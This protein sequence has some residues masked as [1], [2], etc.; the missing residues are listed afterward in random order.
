MRD[1]VARQA[2]GK[3]G[4]SMATRQRMFLSYTCYTN[5]EMGLSINLA[6]LAFYSVSTHF[7]RSRDPPWFSLA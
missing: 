7:G 4:L 1:N 5:Y 6:C 3:P 2:K